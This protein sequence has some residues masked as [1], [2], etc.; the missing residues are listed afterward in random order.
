[1]NPTN[2]ELF[3]EK[4]VRGKNF[5]AA[6]DHALS[7]KLSHYR[8]TMALR[9]YP[10]NNRVYVNVTVKG[11]CASSMLDYINIIGEKH[12][13]ATTYINAHSRARFIIECEVKSLP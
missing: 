5:I 2:S 12:F 13:V 9:E 3:D 8:F 4:V 6:L 1:M 11:G 10:A 7:T